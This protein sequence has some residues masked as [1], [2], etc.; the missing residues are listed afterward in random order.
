MT[1]YLNLPM[2]ENELIEMSH[3]WGE[4]L[5]LDKSLVLWIGSSFSAQCKCRIKVSNLPKDSNM[6]S[7]DC[8]S[9]TIPDL[10]IVGSVNKKY[11]TTKK[12]KSILEFIKINE[13]LI[14]EL[15][16]ETI[17]ITTFI[18]NIEKYNIC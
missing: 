3:F 6:Y 7:I 17:D 1:K 15:C 4:N 11:I 12:L 8:F 2:T 18:R 13:E 5:G 9:I 16:K 14:I 10:E